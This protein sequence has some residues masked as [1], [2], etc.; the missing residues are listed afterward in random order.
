MSA[1]EPGGRAAAL[2][3]IRVVLSHP[4][5]PGNIGAS[6][7]ALKAM[8]L[9]RLVLV[10]PRQFPDPRATDTAMGA[11]DV[12]QAAQVCATL[13]EALAG[14][15]LAI[16]LSARQRDRSPLVLDAREA[17]QL[18]VT[19][20]TAGGEVAFVFGSEVSGLSNDEVIRCQRVARIAADTGFSSLN[21]AAAVQV[22]AYEIR[23]AALGASP[24]PASRTPAATHEELEGLFAHLATSLESV[25]F[26]DPTNPRRLIER[27]RRILGRARLDSQEVNVLRGMLSAWDEALRGRP[28]R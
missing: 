2:A 21:L 26:F 28:P 9:S 13:D 22:V 27:L 12:L 11:A 14:S 24:P 7:R 6:A 19:E 17:A 15:T 18:A 5:G 8:S 25:G 1:P 10:K 16:A 3:R 23:Y 4:T 20:T